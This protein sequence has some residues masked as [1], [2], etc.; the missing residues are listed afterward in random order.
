[1]N[2][3]TDIPTTDQPPDNGQAVNPRGVAAAAG[4]IAAA[5]QQVIPKVAELAASAEADAGVLFD[6]QLV[7][8]I[9]AAAREQ[10]DVEYRAELEEL[11]EQVAG[12]LAAA[13]GPQTTWRAEHETIPIELYTNRGSAREHCE[14]LVRRESPGAALSWLVWESDDE[15]AEPEPEELAVTVDGEE[16]LTGYVIVPFTALPSYAPE[17]GDE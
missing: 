7:D 10:S 12:L 14:A 17:A 6:A 2:E 5:L 1:M 8:E 4:L 15:D 9:A 11:R 16:Q 13:A 3:P